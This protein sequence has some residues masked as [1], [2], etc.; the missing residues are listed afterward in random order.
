M[1]NGKNRTASLIRFGTNEGPLFLLFSTPEPN[2]NTTVLG[3]FS[4]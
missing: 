2:G 1:V 4:H 3:I